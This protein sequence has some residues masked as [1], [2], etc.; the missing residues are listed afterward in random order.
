[1]GTDSASPLWL[2]LGF[3][4][5]AA[6]GVCI[7]VQSGVNATLGAHGGQAFASVISFA[8]GLVCCLVFFAIDVAGRGTPLPTAAS[9]R[10]A[11]AWSWFG[12]PLGAFFVVA[13]IVFAPRLGAGNFIAVFVCS[14]VAAAAGL[15]LGGAAG[16]PRRA[17]SW[18]RWV[19]VALMAGGV[20][21]VT[22]FP[23]A[24][25]AAPRI[26]APPLGRALTH[27]YARR[28]GAAAAAV[29]AARAP[30]GGEPLGAPPAADPA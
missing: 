19:G 9:L 27:L 3:L 5:A 7:A 29:A 28:P 4:F 14:Q 12:G 13:I 22:A 18:Q 20:A 8:T 17:F 1:M 6:S 30:G 21:L 25:L 23:G 16:Y 24:P 26:G 2:A 10:G 15:D 11:P